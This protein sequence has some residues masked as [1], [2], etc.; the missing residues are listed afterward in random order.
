M[1]VYS[2]LMQTECMHFAK[3]LLAGIKLSYA[4]NELYLH[5]VL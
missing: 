5:H 3:H 4:I 2:K 1:S